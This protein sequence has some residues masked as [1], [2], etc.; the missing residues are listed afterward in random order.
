[1]SAKTRLLL[2]AVAALF[3]GAYF[4]ADFLVES[5]E[6]RLEAF[7]RTMAEN[8]PQQEAEAY[9]DYVNLDAYGFRLTVR[10]IKANF[11]KGDRDAFV[12]AAQTHGRMVRGS[13]IRIVS[14]DV[15]IE[16]DLAKASA[17]ASWERAENSGGPPNA[18]V[19]F[20]ADLVR[21][22]DGWKFSSLTVTPSR[23][24]FDIARDRR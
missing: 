15:R 18:Y 17:T 13:R 14:L 12:R 3:F 21:S 9:L 23:N 11:G 8:L 5:E 10:G 7:L 6:E 4:L 22:G 19:D 24:V 1:M 20:K 16:D 2:A